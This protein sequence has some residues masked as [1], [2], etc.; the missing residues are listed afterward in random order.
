MAKKV[1]LVVEDEVSLASI[2]RKALEIHGYDVL[3]ASDGREAL[4][5]ID[6]KGGKIDLL[7]SDVVMAGIG[8]R[9]LVWRL[10]ETHPQIPV[11]LASGYTNEDGALQLM[12]Q[13]GVVFVSK[14][15]DL[16]LLMDTVREIAGT[17]TE[18]D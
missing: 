5:I 2:Y 7:L 4:E 15:I 9:E 13:S 12:E 11:I 6:Q 8:G 18:D 1:V 10:R 3:S 14:P 16:N 17:S